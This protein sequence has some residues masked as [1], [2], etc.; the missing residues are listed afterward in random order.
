[1]LEPGSAHVFTLPPG[2]DFAGELVRGFRERMRGQPPESIGRVRLYLNSERMR[3][4]VIRAFAA[5]G[6]GFL[7]KLILV[8]EL[9]QDPLLAMLPLLVPPLRRRLELT[10]AI[11]LLLQRAPDLAPRAALYDLADSLADLM[12]EMQIEAV[13]V[14]RL[15]LLDVSG[16]SAHW[17][18]TQAFLAILA[19]YIE[20]SSAQDPGARLR[21]AAEILAAEWAINPPETPVIVAGST[22]SRGST[23]VLMRAVAGLPQ[24]A[25]VLPGFDDN[26]PGEVW[27]GM[28]DAL[29]GEDHPQFRTRLLLEN[30]DLT[31][32]ELPQWRDVS[33]PAP[34][35]NRLISLSLRPAPVT[36]AWLTEGQLLPDLVAATENLTLIEA[37]TARA[38]ALAI[39][40]ILRDAAAAGLS[41]VLITPDRNL[42]RRVTTALDRWGILPDDSAGEPLGLTAPGRLLRQIAELFGQKLTADALLVL[43]KHPLSFTGGATPA[44]DRGTHLRFARDLELHLRR[45]G[46]VFPTGGDLV[47]WAGAQNEPELLVWAETVATALEGVEQVGRRA[48]ADHVAHHRALAESLARGTAAAGSSR[49]WEA[50]AGKAA[51]SLME[52]L[53]EEAPHGGL[54]SAADYR[55]LFAALIAGAEAV[56]VPVMHHPGVAILGSREAREISADL[57]IL[58]GLTD[59][60]WP[61]LARPDPWL[62]RR[63][64]QEAGLLLPERQIG[65]AALDYQIA[66]A[67]PKVVLSRARRDAEAETVPSRWLNRLQNL[68]A[69]LPVPGGP[70]ALAAM[71]RRGAHWLALAAQLDQPAARH[72]SDPSL[73]PAKRPAPQPPLAARPKQLSL[74]RV[75]TLIRDP[76][77]IYARHVLRLLPLDPLRAPPDP[78]DRGNAFHLIL[79]NFV[80]QR[81]E[82]ESRPEARLRLLSLAREVLAQEVPFPAAR[83][84]W[85]ARLDRAADHFLRQDG[86]SGGE[87]LVVETA[88]RLELLPGFALYG[89]PDRIDRLEDGRLQL[90]DYKTGAPPTKAQQEHFEK[91]L[92]LAAALAERGGF[93]GLGPQEVAKITYIGLGAGEKAVETEISEA[94]LAEVWDGMAKLI[95]RYQIRE[96][97]FVARRARFDEAQQGDYDHLSRFGEWSTAEPEMPERVGPDDLKRQD[98]P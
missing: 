64:R 45:H 25:L 21:G 68:M 79:E 15:A 1:M 40:L 82:A 71:R 28:Q 54:L 18:R 61:D 85:L 67:A 38:E 46:P 53:A 26:L 31:P 8:S 20:D 5:S 87:T 47:H 60:V 33:P 3:R 83:T 98:T 89:T 24:G 39:A 49:L 77:A 92:L 94:M 56:R 59:G 27:A 41:A 35:R 29:T 13:A 74:S 36:D 84:L 91:Q 6:P 73:Q 2:V 17:A 65:L 72:L 75:G 30:L 62:N 78:R 58:G 93:S 23:S 70:Q 80:R 51:K 86:K 10:R 81:P 48:L 66:M 95:A 14:S 34:A 55:N 88:G 16:H 69:G 57:V 52:H 97:G 11:D 43:L 37:P 50:E 42:S 44:L 4:G 7:P 19:P 76:Y 22:G 90:I 32:G 96:Q 9:A 12:E 63:M